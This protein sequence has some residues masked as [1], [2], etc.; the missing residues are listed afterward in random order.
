LCLRDGDPSHLVTCD[1]C[2]FVAADV[3]SEE[4]E[5][6]RG[7]ECSDH[8]IVGSHAYSQGP[9]GRR[10][11]YAKLLLFLLSAFQISNDGKKW[12]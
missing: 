2:G 4:N 11:M 5:W 12:A 3:L 8:G 7:T 1:P 9:W 10:E 6:S